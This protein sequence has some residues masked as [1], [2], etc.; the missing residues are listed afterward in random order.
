MGNTQTKGT[1][2]IRGDRK[3]IIHTGQTSIIYDISRSQGEIRTENLPSEVKLKLEESD[4]IKILFKFPDTE[5]NNLFSNINLTK[6]ILS[7]GTGS[8]SIR[9]RE[10]RR[11]TS[12]DLLL[13]NLTIDADK[14]VMLE[15]TGY[16][17]RDFQIDKGT[18]L[19]TS[20][21][22][23]FGNSETILPLQGQV[24][25]LTASAVPPLL[26]KDPSQVS[27]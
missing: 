5:L 27:P 7:V 23:I 19:K 16:L 10:C 21:T 2:N 3:N 1:V 4:K 6:P 18:V 15:Y 12:V 20:V 22:F 11:F 17:E 14:V 24:D 9:S 13:T 26:E 25:T 8:L